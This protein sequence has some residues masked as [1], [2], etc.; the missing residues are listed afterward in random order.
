MSLLEDDGYYGV[1]APAP[2]GG[3][4]TGTLEAIADLTDSVTDLVVGFDRSST[5]W[6]SILTGAPGT[7]EGEGLAGLDAADL[8]ALDL[9]PDYAVGEGT[10]Q[11]EGLAGLD[12]QDL[13]ALGFAP[14]YGSGPGV[15]I[16][17]GAGESMAGLMWLGLAGLVVYL[18]AR[19]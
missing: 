13:I 19:R 4:W 12:A 10:V 9:A 3:G 14:T 18:L 8:I 17:A 16:G 5:S 1:A 6:Q 11:G 15:V 2:A 7:V